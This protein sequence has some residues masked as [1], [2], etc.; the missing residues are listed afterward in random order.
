[1]KKTDTFHPKKGLLRVD[2]VCCNVHITFKWK[3]IYQRNAWWI[4]S[5]WFRVIKKKN[6]NKTLLL[7]CLLGFMWSLG[8]E[9][10]FMSKKQNTCHQLLQLDGMFAFAVKSVFEEKSTEHKKKISQH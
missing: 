4:H 1:M 8:A 3:S 9:N 10:C 7:D 6:Q 5:E 2:A